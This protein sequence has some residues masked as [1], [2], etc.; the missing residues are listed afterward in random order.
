[1]EVLSISEVEK[2]KSKRSRPFVVRDQPFYSIIPTGKLGKKCLIFG[3]FVGITAISSKQ[4]AK[5]IKLEYLT[6]I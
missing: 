3:P 5:L 1:M 6:F 4:S 2:A